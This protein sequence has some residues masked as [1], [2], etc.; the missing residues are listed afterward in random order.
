MPVP[1][2]YASRAAAEEATRLTREVTDIQGKLTAVRKEAADSAAGFMQRIGALKIEHKRCARLKAL[3]VRE[4]TRKA[5]S[6]EA[7]QAATILQ[8]KGEKDE[9]LA[10]AGKLFEGSTISD[11]A[12]REFLQQLQYSLPIKDQ[13]DS[14]GN[15]ISGT[16]NG[17]KPKVHV[18]SEDTPPAG[19]AHSNARR[20]CLFGEDYDKEAEMSL[21]DAMR[22][23][24]SRRRLRSFIT[25]SIA[26]LPK[27][28]CLLLKTMTLWA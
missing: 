10:K 6:A 3:A 25:L 27:R 14:S 17:T 18:E 9:I 28:P 20:L 1:A 22:P 21:R 16:S 13:H 8:Q 4:A 12:A 11:A 19:T 7:A 5:A 26:S 15:D 23:R 2:K 24:V